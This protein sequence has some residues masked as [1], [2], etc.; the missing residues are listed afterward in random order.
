M[1]DKLLT[2]N[3]KMRKQ[4]KNELTIYVLRG[5]NK[6]NLKWLNENN[7]LTDRHYYE[8]VFNDNHHVIQNIKKIS[9]ARKFSHKISP[10]L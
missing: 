8:L 4:I 3:R 9:D 1:A 6:S 2:Y 5:T 7:L 10:K